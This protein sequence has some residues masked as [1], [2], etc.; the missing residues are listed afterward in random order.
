MRKMYIS[1]Q[2][3]RCRAIS[4]HRLLRFWQISTTNAGWSSVVR[5]NVLQKGDGTPRS[6]RKCLISEKMK[7]SSDIMLQTGRTIQEIRSLFLGLTED[8][9]GLSPGWNVMKHL[10]TP[11]TPICHRFVVFRG[12]RMN[13]RTL[14]TPHHALAW[15]SLESSFTYIQ[16]VCSF[17]RF[18][19]GPWQPLRMD[20]LPWRAEDWPY[21]GDDGL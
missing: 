19:T 12:G 16:Y 3:P 5:H 8:G 17:R 11:G 15:K 2:K 7:A 4:K 20:T 14:K 6:S 1:L 9:N 10:R 21:K 18:R 13:Y